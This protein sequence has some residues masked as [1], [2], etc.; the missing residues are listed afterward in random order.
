M[1]FNYLL[2]LGQVRKGRVIT[3]IPLTQMIDA[4]FVYGSVHPSAIAMT[5]QPRTTT[6]RTYLTLGLIFA[7][8]L[9]PN[10]DVVLCCRGLFG[11]SSAVLL[12]GNR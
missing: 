3:Y 5:T 1:E 9:S 6:I 2:P 12:K 7:E 11:A 10:D 8:A 4:K